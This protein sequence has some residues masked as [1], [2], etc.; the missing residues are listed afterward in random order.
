MS[1]V[2]LALLP[3]RVGLGVAHT[4]LHAVT[5]ASPAPPSELVVID[6]MPEGV[7]AAA[8]RPEP[9]FRRPPDGRS[10]RSSRAPAAPAV[11]LAAHCSGPTSSTTTTG[12]PACSSTFRPAGWCRRAAPTS[13]P[14]ALRPATAPTSSASPSGS[15]KPT[16]GG[17][18]TG[19]R[20]STRPS[21]SRCSRS[22]RT[23]GKHPPTNGRRGPAF[24]PP[25]S[26]WHYSSRPRIRG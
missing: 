4:V 15:P 9:R 19:T 11:S 18:S 2:D 17:G 6:G 1:L 8:L 16:R 20:C 10:A 3:I 14:P 7:P 26:T 24:A 22:T 12:R 13:T 25:A 23:A 5:P 21:R